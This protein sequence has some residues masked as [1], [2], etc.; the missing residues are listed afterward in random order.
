MRKKI[1]IMM[2]SIC[3]ASALFAEDYLFAFDK[4]GTVRQVTKDGDNYKFKD[5]KIAYSPTFILG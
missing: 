3:A 1:L 4:D 2:I 5:G